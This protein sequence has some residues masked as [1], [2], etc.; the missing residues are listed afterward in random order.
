VEVFVSSYEVDPPGVIVRAPQEVYEHRNC[1]VCG[2]SDASE[3]MTE[4]RAG[5][6]T[7]VENAFCRRCEHWYLRK[8][9]SAAWYDRYYRE[10]W[11]TGATAAHHTL[12]ARAR[13]RL[14][15]SR[16][17][18]R[19]LFARTLRS[20]FAGDVAGDAQAVQLF[21]LL[22]G[23]VEESTSYHADPSIKRVLEVGCGYGG[24]LERFHARGFDAVGTEASPRR[25]EAARS[26]GLNVLD[27]GTE[28]LA[29]AA[30]LA[31]FD[32]VY[33]LQVLEHVV[34]ARPHVE[35]LASLV[36]DDGYVF[37]QVPYLLHEVNVLHRAHSAVHLDSYSPHSL[38]KLLTACGL[39]TLR[40][41]VDNNVHVLARKAPSA[42]AALGEIPLLSGT[43]PATLLE[44]LT[45]V[46]D[47]TA[48][49]AEWDHAF[50][51]I[52]RTAGGELVF[53][54]RVH[55]NVDRQAS[56]SHL[57]FRTESSPPQYPLSFVHEG[58]DPPIYTKQS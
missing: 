23:V 29:A 40:L 32:L 18:L 37:L 13:Y 15:R 24:L 16:L 1:T 7:A 33:S 49:R 34:D 35:Q 36:R 50:V 48:V 22:L 39:V 55:L 56:L 57:E 42:P 46:P 51:E 5:E 6:R 31:P 44:L 9:P 58:E 10:H 20:A 8:L 4:V 52:R 54:R 53:R 28:G 26:R 21:S 41:Q 12:A 19:E 25:A 47:G 45:A 43:D 14:G 3:L 38:A 30:P 2:A 27:T 11:D 17:Q